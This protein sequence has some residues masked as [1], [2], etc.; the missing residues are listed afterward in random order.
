MLKTGLAQGNIDRIQKGME[1]LARNIE[2]VSVFVKAFLS[3]SKG[4]EIQAKLCDP[5]EIAKE[6][7]DLYAV[8][9]D[10]LGIT[11]KFEKIGDIAPAPIDF[12]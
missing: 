3:F 9:A 8:K 10:K 5:A 2:R 12:A 11:L 4:R 6:V 1:M 7:I